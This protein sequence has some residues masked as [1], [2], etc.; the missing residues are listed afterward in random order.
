MPL[1]DTRQA[2]RLRNLPQV[3]SYPV[4]P[5]LAKVY[6]DHKTSGLTEVF[7]RFDQDN[8]DWAQKM[9]RTHQTAQQS[10][11]DALKQSSVVIRPNAG[12]YVYDFVHREGTDS[13]T[14][15]GYGRQ[16]AV[17]PTEWRV[18]WLTQYGDTWL[19]QTGWAVS[20]YA[21][22]LSVAAPRT[23]IVS[24]NESPLASYRPIGRL[25]PQFHLIPGDAILLPSGGTISAVT[26]AVRTVSRRISAG[27]YAVWL[28]SAETV[29]PTAVTELHVGSILVELV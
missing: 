6:A 9:A 23:F 8:R 17:D 26:D 21:S 20:K 27:T 1:T 14:A 3:P 16:I 13:L 25:V 18:S 5:D 7:R 28:E 2:S 12:W 4:P 11:L 15:F 19:G 24:F 10:T 22:S 29:S